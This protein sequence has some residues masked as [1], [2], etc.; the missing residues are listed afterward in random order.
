MFTTGTPWVTVVGVVGD[1]RGRGYLQDIPATMY[2]PYSQSATSAYYLPRATALLVRAVGDPLRLARTV[3]AAVQSED[4]R[5]P[6]SDVS[7]LNQ[8]VGQ[9]IASRV[10]TTLLLAGFA[11]LALVLAGVGI[12][13]VIAYGVSQRTQ[14]IGV[15]MALGASSGSV[16]EMVLREGGRLVGIGLVLGCAGAILVDRFLRSMLIGVA[17]ADLATLSAVCVLVTGVAAAACAF[18]AWRATSV[19]PTEALRLG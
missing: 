12:Y 3:R 10:F 5:I 11:A 15:R 1:V 18:P 17:P 4:A 14:E 16:I 13:G 6:V 7:T 2:F 19:S 9:S 8:I